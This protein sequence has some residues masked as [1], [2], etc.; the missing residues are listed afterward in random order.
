VISGQWSGWG[1]GLLASS[2][3]LLAFGFWLV[4]W[5]VW[6]RGFLRCGGGILAHGGKGRDGLLGT[7]AFIGSN[8]IPAKYFDSPSHKGMRPSDPSAGSFAS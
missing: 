6:F 8:I 5:W 2:L 7:S 3:W 4:G 1:F